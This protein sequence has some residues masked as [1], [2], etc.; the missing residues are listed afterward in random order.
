MMTGAISM[1][2]IHL[3]VVLSDLLADE[4]TTICLNRVKEAYLKT[5]L[6]QHS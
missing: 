5:C 6:S 2:H 4:N 1:P 3:S